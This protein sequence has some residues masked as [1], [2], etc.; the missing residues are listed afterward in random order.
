MVL[1]GYGKT[2]RSESDGYKGRSTDSH[3]P[4]N[5]RQAGHTQS[6]MGGTWISQRQE[7][8]TE[9]K[10]WAKAFIV[11]SV[12]MNRGGIGGKLEEV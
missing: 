4:R 11:F 3:I 8:R 2:P 7:Q 9:E 5:R 12:G 6:P 1:L 10:A